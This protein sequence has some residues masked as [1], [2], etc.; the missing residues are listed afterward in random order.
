MRPL[1][2]RSLAGV[3]SAALVVG[4]FPGAALANPPAP[5]PVHAAEDPNAGVALPPPADVM[6]SL[7]KWGAFKGDDDV[8]KTYLGDANH[9][10]PLGR[11][12]YLSLV[13]AHDPKVEVRAIAE[14]VM[15]LQPAFDKLRENGAYDANRQ[16]SVQRTMDAFV[17][18]FG[19]VKGGQSLEADYQNG[20]LREAL[21][22]GAAVPDPPVKDEQIQVP[23]KD[24]YEFWDHKGLVFRINKNNATTYSRELQKMQRN[25][26]Q[27][28][29]PDVA[30]IPETGRYNSEMF[31][32]SYYLLKNQ[33]DA[34]LQ[35]ME[36]ERAIALAEL[37]GDAAKYREDLWFTSPRI[38]ADLKSKAQNKHY[39]DSGGHD[40]SV[41]D[42]VERK[43]TQREAYLRDAKKAIDSFTTDMKALKEELKATGVIGDAQVQ[44]LGMDEQFARRFL[45]LSVIETQT[46]EIHNQMEHLNASSPDSEQVLKAI[47]GSGMTAIQKAQYLSRADDMV[48]RLK[49]LQ[50]VLEK[51]R[52]AMTAANYAG[53]MDMANAAVNS[54][55]RQL[56]LLSTDYS[57]FVDVP[58]LGF[59]GSQQVTG[60]WSGVLDGSYMMSLWHAADKK[61]ARNMDAISANQPRYA[62]VAQLIA[63]DK[64]AEA[65]QAL[66][67]IDPDAVK[68]AFSVALGGDPAK[69]TDA[70]RL[71]AALQA[72]HTRISNV[73][74]TN[75]ALRTV[76][77]FINFTVAMAIAAPMARYLAEGGVKL[78]TPLTVTEG[79][80]AMPWYVARPAIFIA[81]SLKHV[82]ARLGSLEPD[83]VRVQAI[84]GE[85]AAA[86]YMVATSLRAGS[87]ALRQ[88]SFTATSGVISGAFTAGQHLWDEG[89]LAVFAPGKSATLPELPYIGELGFRP[90]ESAFNS[91]GDA[92]WAGFKGGVI[93]ANKPMDVFGLPLLHP[94]LLGYVGVPSTVFRGTRLAEFMEILGSRGVVGSSVGMAKLLVVGENSAAAAGGAAERGFLEKLATRGPLGKAGAFSLS[95]VD[96]V[97]KY[98][99]FS[100][101]VGGLGRAYD[102]HFNSSW[103]GHADAV[104][105]DGKPDLERRIKYANQAGEKLY[106]SPLWMLIPTYAAHSIREAQGAQRALEGVRQAAEADRKTGS[107]AEQLKIA[108]TTDESVSLTMLKPPKVPL[109]QLFFE[110]TLLPAESEGKFNVTKDVRRNLLKNLLPRLFGAAEG[111]PETIPPEKYYRL[112]RAPEVE[113]AEFMGLKVDKVVCSVAEELFLEAVIKDPKLSARALRAPLGTE[114]EG[115]GFMTT[116]KRREIATKLFASKKTFTPELNAAVEAIMARVGETGKGMAAPSKELVAALREAPENSPKLNAAVKDAHAVI[117][118]WMKN[119]DQRPYTEVLREL[120][121]KADAEL[122]AGRLDASD[123]RVLT[124]INKYMQAIESRF[125]TFNNVGKAYTMALESLEAVTT[126]YARN[127]GVTDLGAELRQTLDAWHNARDPNSVADTGAG[128]DF[129]KLIGSLE[130]KVSQAT[131]TP[132][133]RGAVTDAVNEIKASPWVFRNG[134]G[135]ALPRWRPVQFEAMMYAMDTLALKSTAGRPPRF[136]LKLK[137]GGGKTLLASLGLLPFMEA[138][139]ASVPGRNKPKP[140]YLVPQANLEA[141][142]RMEFA[143]F[144]LRVETDTYEGWKSKVAQGK[145]TGRDKS[146]D[147]TVMGDEG[148]AATQQPILTIGAVSGNIPRR[149]TVFKRIDAMDGAISRRLSAR[150][151]ERAGKAR[152]DAGRAKVEMDGFEPGGLR[153]AM[154]DSA[155]TQAADLEAAT[156]SLA[157]ARNLDARRA[158]ESEIRARAAALDATL[159]GIGADP[160]VV[161]ARAAVKR[162]IEG[163]DGAATAKPTKTVGELM[164]DILR[165]SDDPAENSREAILRDVNKGL[166]GQERLFDMVGS[167]E[168]LVRL[169]QQYQR[170]TSQLEVQENNLRARRQESARALSEY[171]AR[172]TRAAPGSDAAKNLAN[173]IADQ[174]SRLAG[175]DA[176]IDRVLGNPRTGRVGS[177]EATRRLLELF[178]DVDTGTRIASL[179]EKLAAADAQ[180]GRASPTQ[181]ARWKAEL[182]DQYAQW[183]GADVPPELP[184]QAQAHAEALSRLYRIQAEARTV[185]DELPAAAGD[186]VAHAALETR[187]EALVSAQTTTRA[188]LGRLKDAIASGSAESG[189]SLRA[190]DL[191]GML[192]RLDVMAADIDALSARAADQRATLRAKGAAATSAETAALQAD[193]AAI[194]KMRTERAALVERTLKVVRERLKTSSEAVTKTIY[195]GKQGWEDNAADLLAERR[196]MIEA[197]AADENPMYGVFREMRDWASTYANRTRR[198]TEGGLKPWG[199]QMAE[200]L[201]QLTATLRAEGKTD[202]EIQTAVQERR[203]VLEK[204]AAA[205]R[206]SNDVVVDQ[207]L[208]DAEGRSSLATL[209]KTLKMAWDVFRGREPSPET[210]ADVGMTRVFAAKMLKALGEDPTMPVHVRDTLSWNLL[211]SLLWPGS[212]N[213]PSWVR[214]EMTRMYQGHFDD[215]AK[216]RFDNLTGRINVVHNGEWYESMDNATR[217][218]WEL[219]YGADLTLPYTNESMSTIKDLTTNRKARF[220][221][222]SG[223]VAPIL[224][225][226]LDA[227]D[228][229]V[230]G[231]GSSRPGPA[232][233]TERVVPLASDGLG[234]V[235]Q[236]LANQISSRHEVVVEPA[237]FESAPPEVRRELQARVGGEFGET[238]VLSLKSFE[239]ADSPEALR[240]LNDLRAKRGATIGDS[241]RVVL[242]P[243]RNMP[244]LSDGEAALLRGHLDSGA[245]PEGP[246]RDGLRKVLALEPVTPAERTALEGVMKGWTEEALSAARESVELQMSANV[247]VEVRRAVDRAVADNHWVGKD[248]VVLEIASLKG[249]TD[250]ETATIR[251]WM[252]GLRAKQGDTGVVFVVVPDTRQLKS[253]ITL[254]KDKYGLS[255]AEIT[256]VF[257]DTTK[258]GDTRPE[259]RVLQQM[260]QAGLKTIKTADGVK[261]RTTKVVIGDARTFARGLDLALKEYTSFEMVIL[262]P[263]AMDDSDVIQAAGRIDPDRTLPGAKRTFNMIMNVETIRNLSVF[264]DMVRDN[265]F[266]SELRGDPGFVEFVRAHGNGRSPEYDMSLYDDYISQRAADRSFESAGLVERYQKVVVETLKTQQAQIEAE[267]LASSGVRPETS[268]SGGQ[269][270]AIQRA[271]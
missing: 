238:R 70:T 194:A 181:I 254:L 41:W 112:M 13:R 193:A 212:E 34:V 99:V 106:A 187:L 161:Q 191:G 116:D 268:Q 195:S 139:A 19:A 18:S 90:N 244:K 29:P 133:E 98:A 43:F 197:F 24:G 203:I 163:L 92:A 208:R 160:P 58:T 202:A 6:S 262:D 173:R 147:Y 52:A 30:F 26:N 60:G 93:W 177:I 9:L 115:F 5:A 113:G 210:V 88:L 155:R 205:D 256:K 240:W 27:A 121:A 23:V 126:R 109:S 40:V 36:R 213:R 62:H 169:R 226:H 270:P 232:E 162:V 196:G 223:T 146:L 250:A 217:R 25:M 3:L 216:I 4:A 131:L 122:S 266:F 135:E 46:F 157:D 44:S 229:P 261:P 108:N 76:G 154:V 118:E 129:E 33:Y 209:P 255:D 45:T 204:I 257:S 51:S 152:F 170:R 221:M 20:A 94:G 120:Q 71:A 65:R 251:D 245:I 132:E 142:V 138:D 86:R 105:D 48:K 198:A 85:N 16:A 81:E 56:Q 259:A 2:R 258:L 55:Q 174:K 104:G 166:V 241:Q 10:T 12:L 167:E 249:A 206:T 151:V 141:Q 11:S 153:Q 228:I 97:A 61:Y 127:K 100:N 168:G 145:R 124:A 50:A 79:A 72:G 22:T 248:R 182:A 236:A 211:T 165:K 188:E 47:N 253:V 184:A 38:Q 32:F 150:D 103:G 172:L 89:S 222:F 78:L 220:I 242:S 140:L 117:R 63:A 102:Y 199:E 123:H 227:Y 225:E 75:E 68:G 49:A 252:N 230:A 143:S 67:D 54:A 235:G 271:R 233:M 263:H 114:V 69:L 207:L 21:M 91:V 164:R 192:R 64:M 149:S 82:A 83:A 237:N 144:G 77:R 107:V 14:E 17:K 267:K 66:I 158:A 1:V 125:N 101:V 15:S 159:S 95:M 128:G 39:R 269:Y 215:P 84:A 239:G 189:V 87:V 201:D 130:R 186:P 265:E 8:L 35:G 247:P 260:N 246:A 185:L 57:M 42:L 224:E 119:P 110:L 180:P 200:E 74:E 234:F 176:E 219:H 148:D 175:I 134:K 183:A 137:T 178:S 53:S 218:Y 214:A 136:F 73:Y 171:E 179:Q 28:R 7:K 31:D 231:N 37:L 264:R 243:S 190:A 80:A 96:N 156:A 59:Q 111:K